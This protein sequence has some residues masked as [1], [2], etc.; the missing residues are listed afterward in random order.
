MAPKSIELKRSLFVLLIPLGSMM[1]YVIA[2]AVK[3]QLFP[4]E[5]PL[6]EAAALMLIFLA[7]L[8]LAI[9]V[10][11]KKNV[12]MLDIGI[13]CFLIFLF[14]SLC[15]SLAVPA[16]F[17]RSVSL[18]LINIMDN[19][20]ESGMAVEEIRQELLSVYFDEDHAL[21]KRLGE[22]IQGGN[23]ELRDGRYYITNSGSRFMAFARLLSNIYNFEARI[24]QQP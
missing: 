13:A 2:F 8:L 20:G 7:I 12:I 19:Q 17:D 21:K 3:R 15:F 24:V 5:S 23:I 4:S 10:S 9:V 16:V 22:Q 6:V 14:A 18:Y 1:L 11:V